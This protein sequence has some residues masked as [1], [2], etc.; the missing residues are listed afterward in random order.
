MS[1]QIAS[2]VQVAE[3]GGSKLRFLHLDGLS[4]SR[5]ANGFDRSRGRGQGIRR[6]AGAA[7]ASIRILSDARSASDVVRGLCRVT[8]DGYQLPVEKRQSTRLTTDT[9]RRCVGGG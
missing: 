2:G 3:S 7:I 9:D 5:D 4:H 1:I 6:A 8:A